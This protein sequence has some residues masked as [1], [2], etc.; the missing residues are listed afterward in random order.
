MAADRRL[1]VLTGSV[2]REENEDVVARLLDERPDFDLEE[3]ELG[4]EPSHVVGSPGHWRALPDEQHD[5]FTVHVLRR[6]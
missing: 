4:V 5:G 1:C 3:L 2:E 6:R